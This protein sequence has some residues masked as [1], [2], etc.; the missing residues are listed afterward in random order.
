MRH[1]F[2]PHGYLDEQGEDFSPVHQSLRQDHSLK[3]RQT[4]LVEIQ[5][6]GGVSSVRVSSNY[7]R[8]EKVGKNSHG[9]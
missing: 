5:Q 4:L 1:I 8:G 7:N 9:Q 2:R 3:P 6:L